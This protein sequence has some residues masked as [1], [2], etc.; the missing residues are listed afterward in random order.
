VLNISPYGSI[1]YFKSILVCND[2]A[3]PGIWSASVGLVCDGGAAG[4][5]RQGSHG[6]RRHTIITEEPEEHHLQRACFS[7]FKVF[8]ENCGGS[9]DLY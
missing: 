9:L 1:K 8:G 5:S 4:R 7:E 3:E 2:D 6:S